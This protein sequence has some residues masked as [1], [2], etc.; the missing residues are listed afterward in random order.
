[1]ETD[2]RAAPTL[3]V[4]R[5]LDEG[6]WTPHQRVVVLLAA[7]AIVFD[8]LDNQLLGVAVPAMMREWTVNR[9]R[10]RRSSRA[11]WSA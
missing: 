7:L 11:E 10:S 3:D 2:A 4:G 8:R 5:L 1:M 9:G 6:R